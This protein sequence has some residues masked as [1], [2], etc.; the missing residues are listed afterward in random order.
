MSPP[1]ASSIL[2]AKVPP[3]SLAPRRSSGRRLIVVDDDDD[4]VD[5]DGKGQQK[6]ENDPAHSRKQNEEQDWTEGRLI[7]AKLRGWK[8]EY[9]GII[10]GIHREDGDI[11]LLHVTFCSTISK[12]VDLSLK[13]TT[14]PGRVVELVDVSAIDHDPFEEAA[15]RGFRS[16]NE[17]SEENARRWDCPLSQGCGGNL[18]PRTRTLQLK[19]LLLLLNPNRNPPPDGS[20]PTPRPRSES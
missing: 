17:L 19:T 14:S 15:L 16:V 9:G 18:Y 5:N 6:I 3:Q 13:D 7:C 11:A 8:T 12:W 20:T 10:I 1:S 4:D 2:Q